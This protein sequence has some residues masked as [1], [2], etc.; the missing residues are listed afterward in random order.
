MDKLAIGGIFSIKATDNFLYCVF[1][2]TTD[3]ET[4]KNVAVFDWKGNPV[5]M[6]V[7]D[8]N[9]GSLAIDEKAQKGYVI[10]FNDED[11]N[12]GSFDL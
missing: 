5:K 3:H 4:R 9:I 11:I 10:Y 2:A 8:H 1:S 7:L 6:Y 12:L